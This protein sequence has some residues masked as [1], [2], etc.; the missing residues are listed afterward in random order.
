MYIYFKL[1]LTFLS[2]LVTLAGFSHGLS[3][4]EPVGCLSSEPAVGVSTE[5]SARDC[6]QF[7]QGITECHFFS[8]YS[9]DG[10]CLA[11]QDCSEQDTEC[12]DCI[13]GKQN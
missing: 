11:L 2:I 10:T 9:D 7:C 5:S 8:F 6:L 3:C 13:S 4:F 12:I 1:F